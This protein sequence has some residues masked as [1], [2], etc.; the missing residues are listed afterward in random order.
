METPKISLRFAGDT[1]SPAN[2]KAVIETLVLS[3]D[4]VLYIPF[5]EAQ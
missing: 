2:K 5:E 1:M 4:R 3:D